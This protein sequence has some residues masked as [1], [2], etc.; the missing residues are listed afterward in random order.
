MPAIDPVT[1]LDLEPQLRKFRSRLVV[2]MAAR[3]ITQPQ[4]ARRCNLAQ[5]TVC[6]YMVGKRLPNAVGMVRLTRELGVSAD[7]LLGTTDVIE[8]ARTGATAFVRRPAEAPG[9]EG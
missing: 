6:N 2:A 5:A 3:G 7:W 4:L 1:S 9:R 8:T